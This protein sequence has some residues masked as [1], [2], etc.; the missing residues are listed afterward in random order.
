MIRE[1]IP[2][3]VRGEPREYMSIK[4]F[5]KTYSSYEFVNSNINN[6]PAIKTLW[7]ELYD[8]KEQKLAHERKDKVRYN[9][10]VV[11][12]GVENIEELG[13]WHRGGVDIILEDESK[14]KVKMVY[15]DRNNGGILEFN[16][17]NVG[18]KKNEIKITYDNLPSVQSD[19]SGHIRGDAVLIEGYPYTKE[20]L[21]W[22]ENLK[23]TVGFKRQH[24]YEV[25]T[26]ED[27]ENL[28]K[29]FG[30]F[31]DAYLIGVDICATYFSGNITESKR[32]ITLVQKHK[33]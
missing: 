20:Q 1:H 26:Q 27:I 15:K 32:H 9:L 5:L 7:F 2:P 19:E 28:I 8:K 10:D 3:Y 4:E 29:A 25:R 23:N 17:E 6:T 24:W 13:N 16:A 21:E 11:F 14:G 18:V 30:G 31:H 12:F 33:N 22:K